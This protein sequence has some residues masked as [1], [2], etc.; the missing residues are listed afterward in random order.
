[1]VTNFSV[2]IQVQQDIITT[3]IDGTQVSRW[4]EAP[5]L[6]GMVGIGVSSRYPTHP[7]SFDN[8][9]VRIQP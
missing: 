8:I 9:Y 3:F 4:G 5:Y 2:E 1:M 7:T 6:N